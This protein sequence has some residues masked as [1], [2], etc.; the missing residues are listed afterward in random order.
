M[1]NKFRVF[2]DTS[3][4]FAGIWSPVGGA[5][6]VLKLGEAGAIQVIVSSQ[7]LAEI[8]DMLRRKTPA[9]LGDLT[10][11]LDR[12]QVHVSRLEA[13][14]NLERSTALIPHLGDA[15]V[16]ADAWEAGVDYLV[17]LD[18]QHFLNNDCLQVSVPFL[19][20]SPG[21]FLAWFRQQR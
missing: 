17:T 11:L 14:E 5:R 21:D 7:V 15:Q 16:L 18:R 9:S 12:C 19:I 13:G 8:E 4:L 3:A 6:M 20:G 2:L 1:V 10:L